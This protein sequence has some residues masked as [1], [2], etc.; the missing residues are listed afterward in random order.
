MLLFQCTKDAIEALTVTRKGVVHSFVE[1]KPAPIEQTAWVWQLHAVKINRKLVFIAMQAETRFAMVF[2]GLKKGDIESLLQ[3]FFERLANHL[4]WLVEDVQALDEQ[5][6]AKMVNQLL[7]TCRRFD[8]HPKSDRS[9]QTHINEVARACKHGFDTV[10]HLPDNCQEAAG[11]DEEMNRMLRRV[12]GG[13]YFYPDQELLCNTLRDFADFDIEKLAVVRQTMQEI[14]RRQ[15]TEM[16]EHAQQM[17]PQ[18]G[19]EMQALMELLLAQGSKV[20]H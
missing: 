16:L 11:F 19:D 18:K 14:R 8:F 2:W 7:A 17:N 5:A 6:T 9:I 4:F 3:M 1:T 15:Y 13:D 10:G 20:R 12:R